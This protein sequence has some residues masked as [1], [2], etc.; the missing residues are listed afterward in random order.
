MPPRL[1]R[2]PSAIDHVVCLPVLPI[3]GKRNLRFRTKVGKDVSQAAALL[4]YF[5]ERDPG[6]I[7]PVWADALARGPGWK[8]RAKEGLR[9]LATVDPGLAKYLTAAPPD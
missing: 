2:K 5:R 7:V 8:K 9:A 3:V 1:R 6:A 4:E